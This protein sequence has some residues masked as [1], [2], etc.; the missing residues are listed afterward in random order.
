MNIPAFSQFFETTPKHLL[1][2]FKIEYRAIPKDERNLSLNQGY[3]ALAKKAYFKS[4][5]SMLSQ[6]LVLIKTS[7]FIEA[8]VACGQTASHQPELQ[9]KLPMLLGCDVLCP[10]LESL[11]IAISHS[12]TVVETPFLSSPKPYLHN[13][14]F[15]SL[16]V[17]CSDGIWLSHND[18]VEFIDN[19]KSKLDL[20]GNIEDQISELWDDVSI[21][22]YGLFVDSTT[23]NEEL[24]TRSEGQF[25]QLVLDNSVHTHADLV[26]D[27]F[28]AIRQNHLT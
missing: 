23:S 9:N 1:D 13:A 26:Y 4:L 17:D 25:R 21:E 8:L 15:Y 3:Q 12:D 18:W 10:P 14:K 20:D 7:E 22:T 11:T 16:P 2:T 5:E 19:L 28:D 6:P 24:Q 27:Y